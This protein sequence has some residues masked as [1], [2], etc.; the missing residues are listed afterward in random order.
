MTNM[1]LSTVLQIIG[2]LLLERRNIFFSDKR[3]ISRS[4]MPKQ[5]QRIRTAI[6]SDGTA[7]VIAR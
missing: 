4:P 5:R 1:Q 2:A 6:G 7:N 3:V